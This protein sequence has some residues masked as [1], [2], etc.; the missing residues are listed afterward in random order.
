MSNKHVKK[1]SSDVSQLYI[2][3]VRA[4][5]FLLVYKQQRTQFDKKIEFTD[6]QTTRTSSIGW[7]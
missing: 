6:K 2:K 5:V 1:I 3:P 7:R 4:D